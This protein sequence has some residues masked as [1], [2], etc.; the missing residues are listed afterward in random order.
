MCIPGH[1]GSI[2]NFDHQTMFVPRA[3]CAQAREV[4]FVDDY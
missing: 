2:S 4:R 1:A 3:P